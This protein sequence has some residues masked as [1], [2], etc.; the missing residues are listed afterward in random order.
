M[1]LE[2]RLGLVVYMLASLQVQHQGDWCLLMSLAFNLLVIFLYHRGI[3][4]PRLL[5]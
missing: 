3:P 5:H 1:I 4:G 2:M